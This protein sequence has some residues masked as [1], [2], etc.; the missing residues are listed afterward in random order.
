VD[1][2]VVTLSYADG[3]IAGIA[4]RARPVT[5]TKHAGKYSC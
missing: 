5:S 3:R 4:G 1:T 2:A